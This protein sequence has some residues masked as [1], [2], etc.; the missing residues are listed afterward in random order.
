MDK[1]LSDYTKE[2]KIE[3]ANILSYWIKYA[4]DKTYGGIYGKI[5]NDNSITDNTPKGAVLNARFLWTF[6]AANNATGKQEYLEMA[7]RAYN[8]IKQYFL[9]KEYGGIFWS[10]SYEGTPLNTKKQIYALAFLQ[11][12]CSEYYQCNQL[13]EA[14]EIAIELYELIEQHSFDKINNGYFEAFDRE[15]KKMDDVRLSAKDAN[16]QKTMNTHLHV[17]ESYTNLYRIWPEEKLKQ[18]IQLLIENFVELIINTSNN[19]LHL[20]FDENWLPKGNIISYGHDI[21]AA[22]LILEAAEVIEDELLIAKA[23]SFAMMLA[24]ATFEGLDVDGGLW[25][26]REHGQLV[27]EKHWWP[28][29]EAMVG[30]FN[31]WQISGDK[32]YLEQSI[33]SWEFIKGNIIDKKNGEWLWGITH[34]GSA[35]QG[36]DK[37][38]FWKCPYHNARACMELIKRIA[39]QTEGNE[40]PNN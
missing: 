3:L 17:L 27:K 21:E 33:K 14:K 36:Q 12:A 39:V 7:N 25:Y 10:V 16:E 15:W 29:A 9:D 35:I 4:P 24:N 38:G 34:D 37:V 19:H 22:W 18:S 6:A 23:K 2:L 20:F 8:Y 5:A 32:K 30:F 40:V 26:E 11:Y 1:I 13:L 28:Q 31:A